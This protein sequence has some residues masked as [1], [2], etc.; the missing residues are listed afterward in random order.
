VSGDAPVPPEE[1]EAGEIEHEELRKLAQSVEPSEVERALG[2]GEGEREGGKVEEAEEAEEAEEEG[3]VYTFI[4]KFIDMALRA[5]AKRRGMPDE[6]IERYIALNEIEMDSMN[7]ALSPLLR[8]ILE[9]LGLTP[10][11]IYAVLAF[12]MIV[13]PRAFILATY[14]P[15]KKEANEN[16]Q[17]GSPGQ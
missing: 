6:D 1:V 13:G 14:Q 16:D 12:I 10:S 5:I 9:R 15:P 2:E 11:E 3:Q 17:P 7:E 4:G 8:R